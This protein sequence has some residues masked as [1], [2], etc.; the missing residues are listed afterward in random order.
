MLGSSALS[1]AQRSARLNVAVA[2]AGGHLLREALDQARGIAGLRCAQETSDASK[3]N[4]ARQD[5]E[6]EG[7]A[8]QGMKYTAVY[9]VYIEYIE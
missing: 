3:C 2:A 5:T 7:M 4:Q 9:S 8:R 1:E 6:D